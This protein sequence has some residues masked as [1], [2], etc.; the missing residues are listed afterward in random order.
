MTKGRFG[1]GDVAEYGV[2]QSAN[3]V[4]DTYARLNPAPGKPLTPPH[5]AIEVADKGQRRRRAVSSAA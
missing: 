1:T 4:S 3:L 2:I 5:L